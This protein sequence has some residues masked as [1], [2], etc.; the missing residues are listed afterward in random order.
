M[1]WKDAAAQIPDLELR[2]DTEL[3]SY[4]TFRLRSRGDLFVVR[5]L[6]ALARL[7]PLL[8]AHRISW[9]MLGWGANQ[10]LAPQERDVLLQLDLPQD[11]ATLGELRDTYALSAS[12]GLNQL[13]SAALRLGLVGWEVFTGIPASLGGAIAMNA[14]TALGEIGDLVT[15][16]TLMTSEGVVR[17][18]AIGPGSF[19]YR[20]CNFL[21][22]GEVIVGATLTHRGT[23]PEIGAKIRAYLEYRKA[24]QPLSSRNCGCVFKNASKTRQAGRL[25]D[26]TGL[27][28]A[29]VGALRVSHRHANFMENIGAADAED[30]R[31]LARRLNTQVRLYWGVE[32]ELEVK[33]V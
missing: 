10:V 23:S 27:K 12:V 3:T 1:S 17:T 5:S 7:L 2:W 33:A 8:K 6:A 30:F 14:G 4:S 28:G 32:F 16:V 24:S 26:L 19:S 20:K 29:A 22:S 15:T 31:E 21:G 11:T 25:I 18:E 13:T 9:R